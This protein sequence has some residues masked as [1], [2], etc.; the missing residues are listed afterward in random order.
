[1]QALV[2]VHLELSFFVQ[3]PARKM[4]RSSH[5]ATVSVPRTATATSSPLD[6]GVEVTLSLISYPTRDTAP[7]RMVVWKVCDDSGSA[8]C[9]RLFDGERRIEVLQSGLYRLQLY[10]EPVDSDASNYY[11]EVNGTPQPSHHP[12]QLESKGRVHGWGGNG[13]N[14]NNN[15]GKS[16][17]RS[18]FKIG[19]RSNAGQF[20]DS[21]AGD[22]D[23]PIRPEVPFKVANVFEVRLSKWDMVLVR[24]ES[25]WRG[26]YGGRSAFSRFQLQKLRG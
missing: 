14:S 20:S 10:L 24:R 17:K 13:N 4:T 18:I 23:A 5:T 9:F 15:L 6:V 7:E 3:V 26:H 16:D 8:E 25:N 22:G 2:L 12:Q 1:M 19:S 21:N 11:L